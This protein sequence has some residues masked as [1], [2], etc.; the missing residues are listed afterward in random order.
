MSLPAPYDSRE[1]VLALLRQGEGLVMVEQQEEGRTL[2]L[3][4]GGLVEPGE[5]PHEALVRE[6]AEET[7]LRVTDP[8]RIVLL[9][10]VD[11]PAIRQQL[12]MFLFEVAAW[13]GEMAPADPDGEVLSAV[14]LPLAE[15]RARLATEWEGLREPLLAYLDGC[16]GTHGAVWLYRDE[17][18]V[19]R[20]L[21]PPR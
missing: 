11:R 19:Q 2:W 18:G 9:S 4:P 8:G 6:V 3:L 7:G 16:E 20:R 14:L 12:T 1:I 5:L 15:G 10:R 21:L 17:A 13:E